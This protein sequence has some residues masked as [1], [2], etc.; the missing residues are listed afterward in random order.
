[1]IKDSLKNEFINYSKEYYYF[2][3]L[4]KNYWTIKLIIPKRI[5]HNYNYLFLISISLKS[6]ALK[7][8][9]IIK[10]KN[11]FILKIIFS[12]NN[13]QSKIYQ[14]TYEKQQ[15]DL[16]QKKKKKNINQR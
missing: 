9:L 7:S 14:K 12:Q 8:K 5:L 10:V 1:M 13:V 15:Q 6:I 3:N 16:V 11:S 4:K 2:Q